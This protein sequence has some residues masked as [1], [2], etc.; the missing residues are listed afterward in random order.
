MERYVDEHYEEEKNLI[1]EAV[2]SA[3]S[4]S[5][6]TDA[7]PPRRIAD[8]VAALPNGAMGEVARL[9]LMRSIPAN[10]LHP[11][12]RKVYMLCLFER[13]V[14]DEEDLVESGRFRAAA[15]AVGIV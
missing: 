1:L 11:I 7:S 13:M 6:R 15:T 2:L 10:V 8:F 14:A 12:H 5:R 4:P 9:Y 3:L